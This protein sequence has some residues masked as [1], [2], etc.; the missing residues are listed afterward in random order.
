MTTSIYNNELPAFVDVRH[1]SGLGRNRQI[2]D[3]DLL[4]RHLIDG[5]E[6][7]LRG[8]GSEQ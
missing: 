2:A 4:P 6:Q 5:P 1:G 8:G 7:G 3:P